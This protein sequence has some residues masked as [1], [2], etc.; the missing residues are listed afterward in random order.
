MIGRATPAYGDKMEGG[1]SQS[2][3]TTERTTE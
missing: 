1:Y 3:R 2:I